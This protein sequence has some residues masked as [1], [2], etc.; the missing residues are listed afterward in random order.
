MYDRYLFIGLGG[1][2]GSTLGHLKE[3]ISGWLTDHD[4]DL[5]MPAGWQFLHIDTPTIADTTPTLPDDEYLGLIEAGVQYSH[6][7]LML[8]GNQNLH[9]ETQTW[10]VD[11][12]ALDV[13]LAMG[14][15]QF[16]AIGQTVSIA[17]A[18]K[19][20]NRI[21][22]SLQ[23]LASNESKSEIAEIYRSVTGEQAGDKS[24]VQV[25][26]VS[27]L[28]GGT[29]AGLLQTV[30]DIVRAL[31][32]S[33]GERIFGVLYTPEVF[34]SLGGASTG[35]VQ[36]NSL[37]AICELLNGYW[38]GGAATVADEDDMVVVDPRQ[39]QTLVRAGL[40]QALSAS[41]PSYPFLVGRMG[42]GGVDHGTPK[43]LFSMVGRS[44]LSW[45]TDRQVQTD[46]IAYTIGN[47]KSNAMNH[48]MGL[49]TLVNEGSTQEQGYPSFSSLGF[50]RLSIGS[51]HFETYAA[52]RL[53][54][55][56]LDQVSQY[57]I[58]S[59]EAR[60]VAKELDSEDPEVIA[61]AIAAKHHES[62]I[63]NCGL[64]EIGPE[65]ND[66]QDALRP[67]DDGVLLDN[68]R[69]KV[70]ELASIRDGSSR[71]TEEWR[72]LV[73]DG[74]INTLP[75]LM[76]AYAAALEET[77]ELWIQ[78]VQSRLEATVESV[79]ADYGLK[80]ARALCLQAATHL[81]LEVSEDLRTVDFAHNNAWAADWQNKADA[82]FEGLGG[83]KIESTDQRLGE[84]LNIAVH[85]ASM[86]RNAALAER[87]ANLVE[88]FADLVLKPIASAL[89]DALHRAARGLEEAG[90]WPAW[91]AAEPPPDFE[92]PPSEFTLISPDEYANLFSEMLTEALSEEQLEGARRVVRHSVISGDFLRRETKLKHRDQPLCVAAQNKWW[93]GPSGSGAM[94]HTRTR[95]LVNVNV[96]IE[97][98]EDRARAWLNQ[99]G[100]EF[101]RFLKTSL[102]SYLGA[103][104]MLDSSDI[105]EREYERRQGRFAAQLTAAIDAAQ[106]LIN[107]DQGIMGIVHT[108]SNEVP[109]RN[110]S[111]IPLA[112]HPITDEVKT[113]LRSAGVDDGTL[114]NLLSTDNSVKHFD[115]TT[116]LAAPHSILVIESL[117][118]PIAQSWA[119]HAASG[120]IQTFWSR[121]R[122]RTMA[123]FTP[124]P[125]A[126]IHCMVRGWFT[127]VL[128]GLIDRGDGTTAVQIA[129]SDD[130]SAAFPHPV[131]SPGMG[132]HDRL[133]QILEA[134]G[135]AYVKVSEEGTLRP[136]AAYCALRDLGRSEPGAGLFMYHQLHPSLIRW[137][138]DG[139]VPG[140]A[141]T[142]FLNMGLTPE[143]TKIQRLDH[144]KHTLEQSLRLYREDLDREQQRWVRNPSTLSGSPLWTGIWQII[145]RQLQVLVDATEN[146]RRELSETGPRL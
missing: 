6:V 121:R 98:L 61:N 28:A 105:P 116:S 19:I 45:V 79:V 24:N 141:T 102:R 103:V 100:T 31:D 58:G 126:L 128:L 93:P 81:R 66:I 74:L 90:E 113:R 34:H 75:S 122:A 124:A 120:H 65:K 88:E 44:L 40:P 96:D 21:E 37:A 30:C 140:S 35:G 15:G 104:G 118:K 51:D 59:D 80:V 146:H 12:A 60:A 115:I 127:G 132:D 143:S 8:D 11:P 10:R 68:F 62:F 125:Q 94:H 99:T 119:Q 20:R 25:V 47:W 57:H 72:Q 71:K 144:L 131:L 134:L 33:L 67:P 112:G 95:F 42:Q 7:Q 4:V 3:S 38:W 83:K 97:R 107:L 86:G 89:E 17:Y 9:E 109:R 18:T 85:H 41:G 69:Q 117:L 52:R 26:V 76:S 49:G 39:S 36:P 32:E 27:S 1:S 142:P 108:D 14:A 136:L 101:G 63:Q 64:S 53:V 56:A 139:E 130:N 23:R 145:C 5:S 92:P 43:N 135:L 48:A 73:H 87:A 70:T 114:E 2:G 29:G 133:P 129:R 55:D 16:R 77:T 78:E 110:F 13:S 137:I 84:Y 22:Q 54:R 46:F 91:S 123:E 138:D 82:T 50:S 106:P 111:Q